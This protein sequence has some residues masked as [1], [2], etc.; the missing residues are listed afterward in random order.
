MTDFGTMKQLQL[1]A[2]DLYQKALHL[3][4]LELFLR[5]STNS[6]HGESGSGA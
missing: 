5:G 2:D 6:R 3:L 1:P 4:V